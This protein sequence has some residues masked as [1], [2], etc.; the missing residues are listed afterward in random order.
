MY[1]DYNAH[2]RN[3]FVN[4][5]YLPVILFYSRPVY[6]HPLKIL[7][8]TFTIFFNQFNFCFSDNFFHSPEMTAGL[9]ADA[10][11][12]NETVKKTIPGKVR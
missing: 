5:E 11:E 1:L 7:M 3:G 2:A 12:D 6:Q 9:L 10:K 8:A 4:S